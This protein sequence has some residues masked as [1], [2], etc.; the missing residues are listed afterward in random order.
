VSEG[1][2]A[3]DAR[4][5]HPR[6]G[7]TGRL[8]GALANSAAIARARRAVMSR[9]PFPVLESDVRDVVY[10]TWMVDAARAAAHVPRLPHGM[11]LWTADGRTPF[12]ILTYRHGHFGPS[13]LGPARV[14]CPSPLQSNWR[15][16]LRTAPSA[17]PPVRTVL[18]VRNVMD[19]L[20]YALG[21]RLFSDA[22]PTHLAAGFEFDGSPARGCLHIQGGAGSAPNLQASWSA[23]AGR[24]LPPAFAAAFADWP[25]AIDYLTLQDAAIAPVP[26]LGRVAYAGISLPADI[27]AIT[28]LSLDD[29]RFACP[30]VASLA[31]TGPA[32]CFHLPRVRFRA[33]SERILPA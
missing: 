13:L 2:G 33:L 19:S 6:A 12:T 32:L 9:L 14:L 10:M 5:V 21:T 20:V 22:L 11:S 3:D 7:L 1:P 25:A 16:Y 29:A 28:P 8:L 18:F 24:A 23:T 30:F 26:H 27:G 15:L 17:A 4:Y 31:P